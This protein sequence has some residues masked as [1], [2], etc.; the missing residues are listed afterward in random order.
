MNQF[1]NHVI[2]NEP[3]GLNS[4]F[5]E[6]GVD[7]IQR[8]L[9]QTRQAI[10]IKQPVMTKY[11]EDTKYM[12]L[13]FP[14][15]P[16]QVTCSG[17]RLGFKKNLGILPLIYTILE[18]TDITL[19]ALIRNPFDNISSWVNS[20]ALLRKVP[21]SI[22]DILGMDY[23]IQYASTDS[24]AYLEQIREASDPAIRRCL[25]WSYIAS[26]IDSNKNRIIVIRY[27]DL[28]RDPA[29]VFSEKLGLSEWDLFDGYKLE[30]SSKPPSSC[31]LPVVDKRNIETIC[32]KWAVKLGYDV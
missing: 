17:Y 24:L 21:A 20:F 29:T 23:S 15:I 32:G 30:R 11:T 28:I 26:I 12:N 18:E 19:I 4:L 7:L 6:H 8:Y 2:I 13:R 31:N 27:E 16:E 14:W 22:L 9:G 5:T 3:A 10:D 25:L 1:E